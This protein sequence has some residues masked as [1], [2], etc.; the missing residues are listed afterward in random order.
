MRKNGWNGKKP[1]RYRIL[2]A[3]GVV[4]YFPDRIFTPSH[5]IFSHQ[6]QEQKII[7]GICC[8]SWETN[9]SVGVCAT[10]SLDSELWKQKNEKLIAQKIRG[11]LLWRQRVWRIFIII[12][13][14]QY[15]IQNLIIFFFSPGNSDWFVWSLQ[16]GLQLER[17]IKEK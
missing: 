8:R 14:K 3:S 5:F 10:D 7:Y 13:M 6:L 1:V 11:E 17:A 2:N 15:S 12:G 16:L 4:Q 9:V